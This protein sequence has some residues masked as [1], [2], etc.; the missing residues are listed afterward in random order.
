[1]TTVSE[2]MRQLGQELS[3][4]FAENFLGS[5]EDRGELTVWVLP[6]AWRDAARYLRDAGY[7]H[8]SDLTAVDYL[9]RDPRFDLM[10]ILASHERCDFIRLKTVLAEGQP[11]DSL[12]PIWTGSN[13]FEREI[14]DL[15]GIDFS[16]HPGLKRILLPADYQGH[17]LR[18]DY[19]VTGP[20]GS[21]FR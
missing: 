18:K 3:T 2:E 14:F 15:F 12:V 5:R 4:Q 7:C 1:M 21:R 13:W 17:P 16:E 20:A 10:A 8:L 9:D 6:P 19:P 11:V